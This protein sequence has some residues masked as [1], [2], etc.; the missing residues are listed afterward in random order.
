MDREKMRQQIKVLRAKKNSKVIIPQQ[1]IKVNKGV[2]KLDS[3]STK[4]VD[5]QSSDKAS[6]AQT[7][8]NAQE[9]RRHQQ[10]MRTA[11]AKSRGCGGCKRK[12]GN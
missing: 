7:E 6:K 4:R 9:I 8:S 12:L 5:T 1:T 2:I 11:A 3:F 10:I